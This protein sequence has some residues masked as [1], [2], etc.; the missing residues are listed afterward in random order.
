MSFPDISRGIRRGFDAPLLSMRR[1]ARMGAIGC[2]AWVLAGVVAPAPCAAR[3]GGIAARGCNG[4]HNGG[5]EPQLR[6]TALSEAAPGQALRLLLEVE[7]KN[8]PTAGF[9][10][11]ADAGA[12]S[13]VAG[14]GTQVFQDGL[15]HSSPKQGSGFVSFEVSWTAPAEP[16]GVVF[17][18][19]AVSANDNDRSSGDGASST[20]LSLAVGCDGVMYFRDTDRDGYGSAASGTRLDCE[21]REGYSTIEGDC[22]QNDA[23]VNPDAE[24]YCNERDDDCDDQVDEGSLPQAHFPDPDGDGHGQPGSEAVLDCPP[25]P[26]YAPTHDDCREGDDTAYPGAIEICD[27]HDNDCDGQSD[28]RVKP[29]CGVGWCRRESWSCDVEDCE[30]GE[31]RE[32]ECNSFDDDCD[33]VLDESTDCGAD[34]VCEAGVCVGAGQSGAGQSGAGQSAA[35]QGSGGQS[36]GTKGEPTGGAESPED[37]DVDSPM[38]ASSKA[39]CS[40]VRAGAKGGSER[41]ALCALAL[42][43][44]VRRRRRS[45]SQAP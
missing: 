11:T 17:E 39:G 2:V 12:L 13:A 41:A 16:T 1:W 8:G 40:A 5:A 20:S 45:V 18:V 43:L 27:G 19:W 29:T 7:A 15:A 10:L 37:V 26:A 24:E 36:G 30:P 4:C 42:G 34:L 44:L 32:E 31:P 23:E 14:Q 3:R 28:E 25:P 21:P 38:P 9:Y 33:D 22:D 35:G 6:L